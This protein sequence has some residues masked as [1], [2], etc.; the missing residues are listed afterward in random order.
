M[1]SYALTICC[2]SLCR[3]TSRSSKWTNEMPSTLRHDLHRLDE[4]GGLAGRQVDLRDVARHHRLGPEA[5]AREEHLHLLGR[6]VLR[7]VEDDERVVQ[8]A[9]AHE[10]ERRDLDGA[11]LEQPL[12]A[13]DFEHVVERVVERP[14]VRVHLLLQV[15]GQE[16]EL[17]ARFDGRPRQDDA[18]HLLLRAGTTR[19]APSPGTSCPCPPGRCRRRCRA[20]RSRRGSGAG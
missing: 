13:I 2:T 5:E 12:D 9:P 11:A 16:P 7:L 19:P 18:A 6:G 4:A 17:L 15:A 3:T 10:R 8:R 20:G 1:A 14:Q